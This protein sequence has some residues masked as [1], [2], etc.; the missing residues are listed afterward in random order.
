M[1]ESGLTSL[2]SPA[3]DPP[4]RTAWPRRSGGRVGGDLDREPVL[5]QERRARRGLERGV[6]EEGADREDGEPQ[7]R[8]EAVDALG[9]GARHAS[10]I[11]RPSGG[12]GV[13]KSSVMGAGGSRGAFCWR[14]CRAGLRR[15]RRNALQAGRRRGAETSSSTPADRAVLQRR[16]HRRLRRRLGPPASAPAR[17]AAWPCACPLD[18]R[19]A[20]GALGQRARRGT[21][22]RPAP[23]KRLAV[24][25]GRDADGVAVHRSRRGSPGALPGSLAIAPR[26]NPKPGR[27]S[28]PPSFSSPK[29]ARIV[30]SPPSTPL[31]RFD[32]AGARSK[33]PVTTRCGSA[34]IAGV[35]VT[36]SLRVSSSV[37]SARGARRRGRR[38][39]S[40]A[41]GRPACAAP[42]AA[43]ESWVPSG[44]VASAALRQAR[45]RLAQARAA[46]RA[47][48]ARPASSGPVAAAVADSVCSSDP[49]SAAE[50]DATRGALAWRPLRAGRSCS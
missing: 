14:R 31:S 34:S 26:P 13:R 6:G 37:G 12:R 32:S 20:L 43:S 47:G 38:A 21:P 41:R 48:A 9:R 22:E 4:T 8:P 49:I 23:P 2:M 36:S 46:W 11:R 16:R 44:R 40:R 24:E 1:A 45:Q 15:L 42:G 33:L 50:L 25:V 10:Q 30:S 27:V 18:V 7:R 19:S 28:G 35:A 29:N 3:S 17:Q 5:G 39:G